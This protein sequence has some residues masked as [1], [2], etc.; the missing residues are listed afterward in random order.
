MEKE[1][2]VVVCLLGLATAPS[3]LHNF[4][5]LLLTH[6][7]LI[8]SILDRVLDRYLIHVHHV[9]LGH[10]LTLRTSNNNITFNMFEYIEDCE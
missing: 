4:I 10:P 9:L 6:Q 7:Y 1:G 8:G 5:V 3:H 2:I